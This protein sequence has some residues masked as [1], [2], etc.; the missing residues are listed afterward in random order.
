MGF[1]LLVVAF[2][3]LDY[4]FQRGPAPAVKILGGLSLIGIMARPD[5]ALSCRC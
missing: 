4:R 5:P 1:P 3:L 2:V